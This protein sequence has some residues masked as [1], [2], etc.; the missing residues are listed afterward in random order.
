MVYAAGPRRKS[1]ARIGATAAPVKDGVRRSQAGEIAGGGQ[2]THLMGRRS[3]VGLPVDLVTPPELECG[4]VQEGSPETAIAA[5]HFGMQVLTASCAIWPGRLV[6]GISMPRD[7]VRAGQC[8]TGRDAPAYLVAGCSPLNFAGH[9]ARK[10]GW[11]Q[12]ITP[13]WLMW[14]KAP[15]LMRNEKP[16]GRRRRWS[17]RPRRYQGRTRYSGTTAD[18]LVPEKNTAHDV[19]EPSPALNRW[20]LR[21]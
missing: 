21:R 18:V 13:G 2:L 12:E 17:S 6:R 11:L 14:R 5:V 8:V 1:F 16:G 10:P 4:V 7:I 19:P 9:G 20:R 3:C 15:C